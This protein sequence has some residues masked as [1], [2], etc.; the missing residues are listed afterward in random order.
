MTRSITALAS[1]AVLTAL[2]ISTQAYAKDVDIPSL[3]TDK[4][5]ILSTTYG[6]MPLRYN[7]DM[8]VIGDGSNTGLVR[9]FAPKE[10]GK[11]WIS[12][13]QLCQSWPTWYDGK[14]YCFKI[15]KTGA[16]SIK[17]T[18]NDGYSGTAKIVN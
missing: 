15:E 9:F 16:D 8:T 1:A 14:P 17:W 3:I 2:S 12:E 11:W 10:Q 5:V 6:E 4:K 18:R 13:N 7:A